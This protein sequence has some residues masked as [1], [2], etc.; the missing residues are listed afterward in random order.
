MN[1][2]TFCDQDSLD[3]L[4]SLKSKA[5]TMNHQDFL[6]PQRLGNP[7][8]IVALGATSSA[9]QEPSSGQVEPSTGGTPSS[10][11]GDRVVQSGSFTARTDASSEEIM[12]SGV[13]INQSIR[14]RPHGGDSDDFVPNEN[15]FI[16]P[17]SHGSSPT[18]NQ[19]GGPSDQRETRT[20]FT[21]KPRDSAVEDDPDIQLLQKLIKK[22]ELEVKLKELQ[23]KLQPAAPLGLPRGGFGPPLYASYNYP[24]RTGP[25]GESSDTQMVDDFGYDECGTMNPPEYIRGNSNQF[26]GRRDAIRFQTHS[27]NHNQLALTNTSVVPLRQ[28]TPIIVEP[29]DTEHQVGS[30][31]DRDQ[32]LDHPMDY[33]VTNVEQV[34]ENQHVN[35]CTVVEENT[36]IV[37]EQQVATS[38]EPSLN[39]PDQIKE[40][41]LIPPSPTVV[42]HESATVLTEGLGNLEMSAIPSSDT[43]M[44][45]D[46]IEGSILILSGADSVDRTAK[47]S[48]ISV[49]TPDPNSVSPACTQT[50]SEQIKKTS[51]I[52]EVVHN[53]GLDDVRDHQVASIDEALCGESGSPS[54]SPIEPD[55]KTS[56]NSS[57]ILLH[58]SENVAEEAIPV[59]DD[60]DDREEG[61]GKDAADITRPRDIEMI[62]GEQTDTK[63]GGQEPKVNSVDEKETVSSDT[64]GGKKPSE[65][66]LE[67]DIEASQSD[68]SLSKKRTSLRL[69]KRQEDAGN[70]VVASQS[71]STKKT[72]ENKKTGAALW[73][74]K[75]KVRELKDL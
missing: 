7:G 13:P 32:H 4:L 3:D 41:S 62:G 15:D 64:S 38:M 71:P 5:A 39:K 66:T 24:Y 29:M 54:N 50:E 14:K 10:D 59:V 52:P 47:T 51:L 36:N 46:M 67:T 56:E 9:Q 68:G 30:E 69:G 74:G 33:T 43:E 35:T 21:K 75:G 48:Q 63:F 65:K 12:E 25:Y 72:T 17:M 11:L 34:L 19:S 28:R 18:F 70:V 1:V 42:E 31:E 26:D 37:M 61:I 23:D 27:R 8:T 58:P 60:D 55:V 20:Q 53:E 40:V 45:D 44:N 49:P 22:A 57:D 73:S 2:Y 16:S 6:A